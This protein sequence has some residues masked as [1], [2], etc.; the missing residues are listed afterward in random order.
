MD[1]VEYYKEIFNLLEEHHEW[2]DRTIN[3]IA[4]E[5]VTSLSVKEA[6]LSDFSHRY[7]EGWPGERV[8]AGCKYIDKVEMICQEL[9]MKVF[10]AGFA[11]VRPISGVVA[12]LVV[13]TAFTEPGDRIMA[14]SIAS[15][16]HISM[17]KKKYWGTAGRVRGLLVQNFVYSEEEMNID[18]DATLKKIRELESSGK[19]INLYMLGASVFPFPHPVRE[20][21]EIAHEYGSI[22]CYD[23][24]H[25]AGLIAA[26]YFQDPLREGADV[27]SCST[28]KTL[29]GPQHGMVLLPRIEDLGVDEEEFERRKNLI[30][31][32]SFP[33]LLSNHH[34]HNVAGLAVALAEAMKFGRDYAKQVIK[35]AKKLGEALWERGFKVLGSEKG[36]T[37]S[38]VLLVDVTE[39]PLKDGRVV[40][41]KLEE[42]NIIV[43][44]NLL[45]WDIRIGRN[46]M[47]PGG[48]RLGTSEVTRIGM[49]EGEME[50]IAEFIKRVVI[51]GE[52]PAE[53][54]KDV[55]EFREEFRECHYCFEKGR[56]AYE[57]IKIRS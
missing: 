12:N 26:G 1:A 7:A 47:R 40:E 14:L 43:N 2:M 6:T 41:E 27:M 22:V 4:S 53:V 25:V 28:H 20:I 44:R 17:G 32:A 36:F 35:N 39:T 11:D 3:L 38:H 8:Y 5:N 46:Y 34:L 54:A 9:A 13:Y 18:V 19:H 48:I 24:S 10:K 51:D 42:A 15:G 29:P 57:Y 23:A 45:P 33:G 50:A 52:K 21:S 30:K 37:E 49:K 31:R 55:S 16:G 56:P